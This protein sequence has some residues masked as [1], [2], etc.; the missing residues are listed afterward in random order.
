M[1]LCQS[2]AFQHPSHHIAITISVYNY[3]KRKYTKM[4]RAYG[5]PCRDYL[6]LS[7][8][9][10]RKRRHRIFPLASLQTDFFWGGAVLLGTQTAGFQSRSPFRG[11]PDLTRYKFPRVKAKPKGALTLQNEYPKISRWSLEGQLDSSR[12]GQTK[13]KSSTIGNSLLSRR[14]EERLPFYRPAPNRERGL[15]GIATIQPKVVG[16]RL[17]ISQT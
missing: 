13:R 17:A 10:A 3:K 9:A 5:L 7:D 12:A 1:L 15:I 6:S 4:Q 2:N 11:S 14:G 16:Y 8:W